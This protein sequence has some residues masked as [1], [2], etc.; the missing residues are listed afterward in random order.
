MEGSDGFLY[1]TTGGGFET[2]GAVFKLA[3]DGSGFTTLRS[4]QCGTDGCSP[5]AA[6]MEA[7][8]GFLYGTTL[9]GGAAANSNR[10]LARKLTQIWEKE[11]TP[12]K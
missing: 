4:F 1:R 6:V 5:Q 8:D 9:V 12:S 2:R 11:A 3:K 10:V 7:S